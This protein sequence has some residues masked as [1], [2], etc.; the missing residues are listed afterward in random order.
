MTSSVPIPFTTRPTTKAMTRR[1]TRLNRAALACLAT[2]AFAGPALSPTSA[3]ADDAPN[4]TL[5]G[6]SGE[7]KTRTATYTFAADEPDVRFQCAIDA[8]QFEDCVSPWTVT[9]DDGP[10]TLQIRAIDEA[11]NVDP[12]PATRQVTVDT[13]GV[14]TKIDAGPNGLTNDPTPSFA[15]GTETAGSTFECRLEGERSPLPGFTQCS[16]PLELPALPD[17]SFELQVRAKSPAGRFDPTPARRAFQLDATAPDTEITEGPPE[18]GQSPTRQPTVKGRSSEQGGRFECRIDPK[19]K[20]DVELVAW[21]NCDAV[22]GFT[23]PKLSGGNH[24]IEVRAIDQAGN[25]DA[26]PAKRSFRVMACENDVRFGLVQ[27]EGECLQGSGTDD[28]PVYESE[29][30]FKLNGFPIPVPGG[31]KAVI[32]A[33]VG[34]ADGSLTVKNIKLTVAGIDLLN[35]DLSMKL[36]AGNQGEEKEAIAFS[37]SGKLFGM[38]VAGKAALRLGWNNGTQERHAVVAVSISLPSIF[39]TGPA[40]NA[41]GVTGDVGIKITPTDG[42]KLDGLKI[43][44]GNVYIGALQVKSLC[45][46]YLRAGAQFVAGCQA[47]K[48]GNGD[49]EQKPFLECSTDTTKDRWDGAIAIVLPTA[50]KTELGVWGGTSDG[51][52]SHGGA[53]ADNLG[54]AVPLAPGIFLNRVAIGVCVQPPPLKLKG[55]VGIALGPVISGRSAVQLNGWV[56]YTD[57]YAN[58][59]WEIKAGGSLDLL[60]YRAAEGEVTYKSTGSLDFWFKAGFDFKIAKVKGRVDGWVETKGTKKFNVEGSVEVCAKIIGCIGGEALVSSVG[61]AGCA[62]IDT[63]LGDIRGGVGFRWGGSAKL[64]GG[65]CD[66]GPWRARRNIAQRFD[67]RGKRLQTPVQTIQVGKDERALVLKVKG[68]SGM[69]KFVLVGPDGKRISTDVPDGQ[70][71][72]RKSHM[73]M[74]DEEAGEVSIL[75][76]APAAGEWRIEPLPGSVPLEAID[77]ADALPAA[78]VRAEVSGKAYDRTVEWSYLP[79]EG[80]TI[81]FAELAPDTKRELGTGRRV[82]CKRESDRKAGRVCGE[83]R[84]TP[85]AGP[86]GKRDIHVQIKQDGQPSDSAVVASYTAPKD[87]LPAKPRITVT[88]KAGAVRVAFKKVSAAKDVNIVIATT[89]GRRVLFTR[90]ANKGGAVV[91][92][93]VRQIVGARVTARGMRLDTTEG[94]PATKTLR[95]AKAKSKK[96]S[97]KKSGSHR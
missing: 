50:S 23:T 90:P 56:Q 88:R 85:G 45:L 37:P 17:G 2:L 30:S 66:I 34:Q 11:G 79:T 38:D 46:S 33:P 6:P 61:V 58:N 95:A 80:R 72:D 20:Q 19:T 15:F 21:Q 81:T 68:T 35:K 83:L 69:P 74:G 59:P 44:V 84:F 12:T 86:G 70:G 22:G 7:I 27:L 28:A 73:I 10:H 32:V 49:A 9:L 60:G 53:Y 42:V 43:Q 36:P 62:E 76:G 52:F 51:K 67:V 8:G 48:I 82:A 29:K 41:G 87:R 4:A 47:P 14:D 24:A 3:L 18:G 1:L 5:E 91:L 71:Y 64:M 96:K 75:V 39:K 63:F 92:T 57:K 78:S 94:K 16:S 77:R 89:D 54:T 26:T 40:G 97:T 13:S 55:E 65:S 31:S 93:G 25:A